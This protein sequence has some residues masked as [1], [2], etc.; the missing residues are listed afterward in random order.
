MRPPGVPAPGE[1]GPHATR[2][3]GDAD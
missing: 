2:A 3:T 1:W